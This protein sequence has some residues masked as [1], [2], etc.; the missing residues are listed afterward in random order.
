M[1][2]IAASVSTRASRRE[3]REVTG[4]EAMSSGAESGGTWL[5]RTAWTSTTGRDGYDG[6]VIGPGVMLAMLLSPS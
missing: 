4:Y 2:W 1:C 6:D 5:F 3:G